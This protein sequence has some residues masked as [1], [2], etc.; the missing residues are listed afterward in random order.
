MQIREIIEYKYSLLT[1]KIYRNDKERKYGVLYPFFKNQERETL[2]L[3]EP[4][5]D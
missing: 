5:Q 3:Q 2:K 4:I 1:K